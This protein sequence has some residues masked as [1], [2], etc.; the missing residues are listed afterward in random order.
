MSLTVKGLTAPQTAQL[1]ILRDLWVGQDSPW[2]DA[3]L[4]SKELAQHW[5]DN[6]DDIE[7]LGCQNNVRHEGDDMPYSVVKNR[8]HHSWERHYDVIAK[9]IHLGDGYGL[10]YNFVSG[11]GKHG[12]PDAYKWWTEAWFVTCTG[13]R[14]TIQHTYEDIPEVPDEQPA[15]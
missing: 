12:E 14:T 11:G 13:T 4:T 2:K 6:W 3:E 15:S 10:A 8:I 1:L 5:D 7:N 9:V